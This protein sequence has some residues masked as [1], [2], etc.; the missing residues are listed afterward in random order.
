MARNIC[1]SVNVTD[2][3]V[4]EIEGGNLSSTP[5]YMVL[6]T[7]AE[8]SNITAISVNDNALP[9]DLL[10]YTDVRRKRY[11]LYF[12]SSHT[13]MEEIEKERKKEEEIE[14]E[15][16]KKAVE[17][18]TEVGKTGEEILKTIGLAGRSYHLLPPTADGTL[19]PTSDQLKLFKLRK[20]ENVMKIRLQ[21]R[22]ET[23]SRQM[24]K[25]ITIFVKLWYFE[26]TTRFVISDI[27]GTITR[28][29]I[30]HWVGMSNSVH[31]SII[32]K[33][34]QMKSE[35][36]VF[37]YVTV[38]PFAS[39]ENRREFLKTIGVPSGPI[40]TCPVD[41]R[42]IVRAYICRNVTKLKLVHLFY[43]K[44]MFPRG[45]IH[46]AFGNTLE[47]A[48]VYQKTDI[49]QC[50]IYNVLPCGSVGL[51]PPKSSVLGRAKTA[52]HSILDIIS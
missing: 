30:R 15:A 18:L 16:E 1:I 45:G 36:Y 29:E 11:Q 23:C 40:L 38:R 7:K 50:N 49:H 13:S 34:Q 32:D 48:E 6:E 28:H 27:D 24:K 25:E 20:G 8:I 17:V 21:L 22:R 51:P 26:P 5:F 46:A 35:G 2:V 52:V 33:F 39:N 42:A 12:S 47:D 19:C 44:S 4:T 9:T 3:I 14:E 43:L 31:P 41:F 37:I 10:Q